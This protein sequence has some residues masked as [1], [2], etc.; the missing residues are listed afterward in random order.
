MARDQFL[1]LLKIFFRQLQV[2]YFVAPSL[3]RTQDC[4]LLLLP[5]LASAVPLGSESC[6][7]KDHILLFQFF[8]LTQ[9]GRPGPRIYTR[10]EQGGP[11]VRREVD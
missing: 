11:V 6:G 4:N 3:T 9:P 5:N 10:Q 7:S 8:R 2:C 1:F